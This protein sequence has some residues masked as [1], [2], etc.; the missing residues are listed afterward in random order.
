MCGAEERILE[1]FKVCFS[2]DLGCWKLR[3]LSAGTTV[4]FV[5]LKM[6]LAVCLILG[7]I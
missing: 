1:C 2:E 4:F 6:L 7:F 5:W 3:I